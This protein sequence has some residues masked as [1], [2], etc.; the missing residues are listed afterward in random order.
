MKSSTKV[1][2]AV[3]VALAAVGLLVLLA[4]AGILP[5]QF[6]RGIGPTTGICL[7]LAS[8]ALSVLEAYLE[9]DTHLE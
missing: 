7:V 5:V 8:F 1:V 2:I 4:S 3:A 6:L 9:R